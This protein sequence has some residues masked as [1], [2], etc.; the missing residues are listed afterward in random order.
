MDR[1]LFI[2]GAGAAAAP[3]AALDRMPHPPPRGEPDEKYW[4]E[5]RWHF[6]I[7]LDATY[8]NTSTLGA[9]PKCV[10][11][12]V[13]AHMRWV[14]EQLVTCDYRPERPIYLAGYEDEPQ[15]RERICKLVGGSSKEEIALIRNAT[16]GM[17]TI[18]HGLD[19]GAGDEVV[20]TDQEHPGGRC[21][22]DVRK[23]RD[24]IVIK[25]VA[26]PVPTEDP[27]SIV[28]RFAA[29]I[30]ERTKVVSIP[31]ITSALGIVMP[32]AQIT[33]VAKR[34][35]AF[36][37]VDGAQSLGQIPVDVKA[38]GCDAFYSSPHKW[39]LAPKGCGVLWIAREAWPRVHTTYASSDWK[40]ETDAGR[41]ISQIGTGNQSLLKGFE[42]ALDFLDHIGLTNVHAR[43]RQLGDA[44]RKGLLAIPGTKILSP[45]HPELCS[46]MVTWKLQGH[47]DKAVA[48]ELWA[49]DKIMSRAMAKGIRSS[50]HVYVT[51]SD[52]ERLL[53][54]VRALA[55]T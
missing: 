26:I 40:L 32:V 30:G 9:S 20:M 31:H 33:H 39:L 54:R 55:G 53:Q 44:L 2:L 17:N 43:I 36:V 46:G 3:L 6:S 16:V 38:L 27:G 48:S 7:P 45:V 50:L 11:D 28:A 13:T 12:T 4:H 24:G 18:A 23:Q 29:V 52:I 14:E 15:L 1:R 41:R 49:K 21:G 34:K 5:L 25:E 8:C 19:L 51:I 22:Y 42:A 47:E 37:V 10:I 35:G